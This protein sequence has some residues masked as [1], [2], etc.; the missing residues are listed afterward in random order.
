M[1]AHLYFFYF[2]AQPIAKKNQKSHQDNAPR[3]PKNGQKRYNKERRAATN[4]TYKK[5]AVQWLNETLCF[6]SAL[7][8]S[9]SLVNRN[10]QRFIPTTV[11]SNGRKTQPIM[12]N[13]AENDI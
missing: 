2:N 7:V 8:L 1:V 6:V 9:D 12:T 13:N 10:P 4:S 11:S 5:L 3:H